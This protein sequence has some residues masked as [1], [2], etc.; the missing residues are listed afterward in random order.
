MRS[1][2]VVVMAGLGLAT[3][4]PASAQVSFDVGGL[5]VSL[6]GN[7]FQGV[8]AGIGADAQVRFRLAPSTLTLGIGG[9]YTTHS[10]DG[11]TPNFHV[12]GVFVEPRYP[13]PSGASQI[14]PYLAARAGYLHQSISQ[15]GSTLSANGF[16]VGGGGGILIGV[17]GVDIDIGFLFALAN[18]G[19][20]QLNGSPTGNSPNGTAVALRAGVV[21]GGN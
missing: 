2:A 12:Y 3:V 1:I 13:F 4:R 6:S 10:V 15:G 21:F 7:D 17:G 20:Q 16:M 18:F 11:F 9:Q 19:E 5:Y 8:N 14:A